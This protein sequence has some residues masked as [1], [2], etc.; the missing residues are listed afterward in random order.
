M[1]VSHCRSLTYTIIKIF[2][3]SDVSHLCTTDNRHL[4][5]VSDAGGLRRRKVYVGGRKGED[6]DGGQGPR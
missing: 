2:F 3:R 4:T 5:V 1:E 6:D